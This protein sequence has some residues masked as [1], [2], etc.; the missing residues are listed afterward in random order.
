VG[1]IGELRTEQV[2]D[3]LALR[4]AMKT[5][6][7]AA[8]AIKANGRMK[9]SHTLLGLA[10]LGAGVGALWARRQLRARRHMSFRSRVV[11]ITGG[12]RGLGLVLAR[13]WAA[14]G[15]RLAL[16]GRDEERL[17]AAA[18]ELEHTGAVVFCQRCD[19][20]QRR[21]VDAAVSAIVRHYGRIDIVVNNAGII[22]VGPLAHM[23]LKDFEEAM[24]VHFYGPLHM[25]LA[26]LPHLRAT[27][28]GRIVNISSIGGEIA[29]PHLV[30]YSA[31]KFALTG[32]S[33]G[34]TIELRRDNIFVTTVCP[35]LMRTGSPPNARFKG[36]HEEEYAWFTIAD[37]IPGLSMHAE[38][39]AGRIIDACRY[40]VA[41][42]TLGL[43]ASVM[44]PL[45]HL[46]PNLKAEAI[47]VANQLL[48]R[49]GD[50]NNKRSF[51]GWE[52]ESR[53]APSRWTRTTYIAARQNNEVP[54]S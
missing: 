49:P 25:T 47:V 9:R 4:Y 44:I 53:W 34:L 14:E 42:L 50:T 20:S 36:R 7:Q 39:A 19:V 37:S 22:Q 8:G 33:E 27:G 15:A 51:S 13:R 28:G 5:I 45:A 40:G 1:R 23:E 29:A 32:L 12:S 46:F 48:P 17:N 18:D 2:R 16:L 21:E 24:G 35:S 38:R 3:I 26:A 52:S 41:H 54:L 11:V 31:S 30:P 10:A 6:T 43:H